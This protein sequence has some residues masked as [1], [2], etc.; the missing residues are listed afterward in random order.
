MSSLIEIQILASK[1]RRKAAA[2]NTREAYVRSLLQELAPGHAFDSARPTWNVNP[3][4]GR[5]L[6][7]DCYAP[8]LK[9]ARFPNGLAVE[10]QGIHHHKYC[11]FRHKSLA[12][13][14]A[15]QRRDQYTRANCK[16]NGVFLIET[17]NRLHT[18]DRDLAEWISIKMARHLKD[19]VNWICRAG[20]NNRH[21]TYA[22]RRV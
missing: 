18:S 1:R 16:K 8:G 17:P 9:T 13:F 14:D 5:L 15:Y 21:A 10:V 4:S 2:R 22:T 6:E 11:A 20:D 7:L 3:E 19:H 12:D